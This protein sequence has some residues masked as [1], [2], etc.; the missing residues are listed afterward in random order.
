MR[1]LIIDD[2]R[3]IID[4]LKPSLKA[5]GFSVEFA[6]DGETGLRM[7]QTG[8]YDLVVVDNMLPKMDGQEVCMALRRAG[9]EMPILILSV[10]TDSA[11]KTELLNSGADDYLTKPFSI[12][13]L[14]ARIRAL[15]RRPHGLTMNEILKTD[16]L[17]LDP[18]RHTVTVDDRPIHLTPKEFGL[19]EYLMRNMGMA[20][21][22]A[23]ILETVWD[24]NADPFSNTIETHITSLRR[25]LHVPGKPEIIQ[26]IHGLGYRINAQNP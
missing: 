25:K 20:V 18:V 17:V 8:D 10:I 26:T 15:L 4:F 6:L 24:T 5:E 13:E 12:R 19:L 14:V 22:R 16:G 3:D 23:M 1:L 11:K 2:E 21:S 9:R 7:A